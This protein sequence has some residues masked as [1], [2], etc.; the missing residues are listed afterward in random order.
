MTVGLSKDTGYSADL[1]SACIE[2]S[3]EKEEDG[4]W[5]Q[6]KSSLILS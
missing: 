1:L 3:R 2:D 4:V 5:H 6:R